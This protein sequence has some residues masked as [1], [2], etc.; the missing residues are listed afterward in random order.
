VSW[1]ALEA[2]TWRQLR[3]ATYLAQLVLSELS[4]SSPAAREALEEMAV[5][6]SDDCSD[7]AMTLAMERQ[8]AARGR[9]LRQGPPAGKDGER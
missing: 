2:R 9:D 1:A 7:R 8:A 5:I 6:L 3:E 4:A